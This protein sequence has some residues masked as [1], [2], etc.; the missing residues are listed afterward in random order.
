MTCI[1]KKNESNAKKTKTFFESPNRRKASQLAIYNNL[2]LALEVNIE[3]PG[4][5]LN[6]G[7]FLRIVV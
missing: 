2:I 1:S 7:E 5:D 3:L 4:S 6:P